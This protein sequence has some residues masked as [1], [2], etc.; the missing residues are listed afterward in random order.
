LDVVASSNAS[1]T[2]L[3]GVI[4]TTLAKDQIK[5]AASPVN[6]HVGIL[7]LVMFVFTGYIF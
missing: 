3:E 2:L 5:A 7:L 4:E 6:P 1:V